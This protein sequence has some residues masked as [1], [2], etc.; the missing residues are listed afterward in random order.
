MAFNFL[1]SVIIGIVQGIS[2]WLPISSKTQVL[3]TSTVLLGF[4]LAVAYAFGL[5]MEIGSTGSALVYFRRDVV[6]VFRDWKLFRF[7]LLVTLVTG[8]VAVPLY[9]LADKILTNSPYPIG[10][11][12]LILG[13]TLIADSI[14]IR[15]SRLV[16]KFKVNEVK[17]LSTRHTL[18]IGLAQGLAALPGVSRS[19]ATVSAM[20]LL[21]VKPGTAFRLSYL[22]YIPASV[23]AF[24]VS[25]LLTKQQVGTAIAQLNMLGL[26]VAIVAAFLTGL[27]VIGLLLRFAKRNSIY[28]VTLTFGILAIAFGIL[29]SLYG[30]NSGVG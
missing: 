3:F 22:A 6:A 13:V 15:K 12:M 29:V 27:V 17:D 1:Y 10:I 4:P 20:L 24:L 9:L 7:L 28:I 16:V 18:L 30:I 14:L 5:F 21:G 2:E 25:L 19:G 23:G 11:P 8:I 26:A